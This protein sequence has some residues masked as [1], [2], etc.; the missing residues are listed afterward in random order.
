MTVFTYKYFTV[1]VFL[2]HCFRGVTAYLQSSLWNRKFTLVKLYISFCCQKTLHSSRRRSQFQAIDN[3]EQA[4]F[5]L[6]RQSRDPDDLMEPSRVERRRPGADASASGDFRGGGRA[7]GRAWW[8]GG[9]A[10]TEPDHRDVGADS[11]SIPDSS[12]ITAVMWHLYL[13]TFIAAI[14]PLKV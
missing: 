11:P 10:E 13:R 8:R 12:I 14:K 3:A 1:D 7:W 9:G 4:A 6:F 2:S 5:S